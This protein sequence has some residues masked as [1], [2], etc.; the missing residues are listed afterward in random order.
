MMTLRTMLF[1]IVG[2]LGVLVVGFSG[3]NG[4]TAYRQHQAH[5]SFMESDRISEELLKLSAD[6]AL[7][8]GYSNAPLHA[9][10]A[11]SADHR[12][13]IASVRASADMAL[14]GVMARLRQTPALTKSKQALDETEGAYRDYMAFRTKVDA[15]LIKPKQE[16][17]AEVVDTFA[18]T[19]TN[20]IDHLNKIRQIMEALVTSPD[21]NMMQLVQTRSLVAEMAEEAGRERAVFGGNIAQKAPFTQ[22][23]IRKLSEHRGHIGLVWA[24]LPAFRLPPDPPPAVVGRTPR[25][26]SPVIPKISAT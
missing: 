8:R 2:T 18:P 6:L 5:A 24:L 10:D 17:S 13:E 12:R 7:E 1:C 4:Y 26:R 14:P 16:R 25:L 23:D 15:N 19:I 9:P 20:V 11:L 22:N 21:S 3:I